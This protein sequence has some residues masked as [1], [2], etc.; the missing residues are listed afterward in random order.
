VTKHLALTA[1]L[2][3]VSLSVAAQSPLQLTAAEQA[4]LEAAFVG[5]LESVQRTISDGA[6]VNAA[7]GEGRT[8]LM[9]AAFNGHTAVAEFLVRSGADVDAKEG[10]GRTALMFASSGP[11]VETVE[12]LLERGADVNAR[13]TREGFTALMTASAEGLENVVQLLLDR[14]ADRT[15]EDQDGDTALSFARQNGH[16]AVVALLE[17]E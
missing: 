5:D 9:Y 13:G 17:K 16:D 6:A 1:L 15:I 10:S 4:L 14:G 7:D 3:G 2:L 11:Y 12:L 8:P